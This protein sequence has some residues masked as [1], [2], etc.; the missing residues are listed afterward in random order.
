M[1]SS[2]VVGN[3]RAILSLDTANFDKG[4][5][6]SEANA[7]K[8]ADR[9]SKDLAPSQQ[10]INS[11]IR[12]FAGNRDIA[13]AME[14]ATA[15]QHVGGVT[16][17]T[18]SEQAKTN[19]VVQEAIEKYKALGVEAPKH[20]QDLAKATTQV[21][22]PTQQ[23]T[24]N[25]VG[26]IGKAQM[27]AGLFGVTLGAGALVSFATSAIKAADEIGDLALKMGVSVE[28][29]QRFRFAARQSGSDIEDVSRAVVQM[30][31]RLATGD[32]S[33]VS[34][35]ESAGLKFADIRAMKPEAAFRTIA[36]AIGQIPDPMT[37]AQVAMDLFGKAG[38]Q[39]LPMIREGSLKAAD[40][41]NVM[42]DDTVRRLKEAEQAW[43]NL[44]D[45]VVT[46][47]GQMIA[48]MFSLFDVQAQLSA[49]GP[50]PTRRVLQPSASARPTPTVTD[51]EALR[52]AVSALPPKDVAFSFSEFMTESERKALADQQEKERKA[53]EE[54]QKRIAA[55]IRDV[56]GGDIRQRI[57]D[58]SEA[59]RGLTPAAFSVDGWRK[60][61]E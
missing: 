39:L 7:K 29:T 34:A 51:I 5:T 27:M 33:T 2:I 9:L 26:L 44:R 12:D 14:Y 20:L 40:G 31:D 58:L 1:A 16:K 41:I 56:T 52:K 17:L 36:D 3:L 11:L 22:A 13:R 21:Q 53:A 55:I 4:A 38:A 48:S 50:A 25:F 45:K 54:H 43:A 15:V 49:F 10:K 42:S 18:A 46:V 61:R 47:T 30:N 59:L 57:H 37:Q 19:R 24:S 60:L 23:L 35:L 28:A 8:L 6:A 32:K